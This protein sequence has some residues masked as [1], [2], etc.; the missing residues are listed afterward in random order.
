V[1]SSRTPTH[2]TVSLL[3]L[4][5]AAAH[6]PLVAEHLEEAPY[7]GVLFLALI[8]TCT[9]LAVLV[10]VHDSP[11]VWLL[12]GAVCLLAV[13]AFLASRTVGLPQLADDVGVWTEPMGFPALVSESLVVALAA[14]HLT[15][16]HA[17]THAGA[18]GGAPRLRGAPTGRSH[19]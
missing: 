4:V 13:V 16:A 9:G 12:S 17:G 2:W 1:N 11:P 18:H 10:L 19:R 6:V 8:L 7:I 5:A 15:R 14:A 3:L